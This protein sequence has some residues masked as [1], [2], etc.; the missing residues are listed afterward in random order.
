MADFDLAVIGSGP[1]GYVAAIRGAQNGL[2]VALIEEH[3]LGGICLNWGC[4]PTKALLRSAEVCREARQ[5]ASYGIKTESVTVD[6]PAIITRS[7]EVAKSNEAGVAFLMKK[8][9]IQ[10]VNGRAT[11]GPCN[12]HGVKLNVIS[13]DGSSQDLTATSLIIATGASPRQ[14]APYPAD[15]VHYLTYRQAMALQELPES[16]LVVGSG[17]IG[18]ELAWFFQTLGS[19][20]TV[21]ETL[22]Q[23]L[24][25]ED[26]E[27]SRFLA[28]SLTKQG[29]RC[30]PGAT[31]QQLQIVHDKVHASILDAKGN[32]V[33]LS[34]SKVLFAVGMIPNT[35]QLGLEAEGI[36]CDEKGFIVVDHLQRTT[37][38]NI[39]AIG[40]CTGKQ[41]LAHKASAEAEVAISAIL[42]HSHPD[43][44]YTQI[45]SALYCHPQVAS[46]GINEKRAQ[47]ANIEY[48]IGRYPFQASGKARAIGHSE[49][50]IKLLF[51][52]ES[53]QL[54]GAQIL[55]GDATEM[56]ATLGVAIHQKMTWE[57]IS[58]IVFAH[59]TL[60]EAFSEA[61]LASQKKAV[62]I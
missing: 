26:A 29:I 34:T 25:A 61:A 8:H 7:R 32:K 30:L 56:I 57:Q 1:G 47:A 49:G 24:P 20:V 41:M 60:S 53:G 2:R 62:H 9:K 5:A 6:F 3:Q 4:I 15:G 22:P 48:N 58:E 13:A 38:P 59:P 39:Y 11:I 35:S 51:H 16:L 18:L 46:I 52:K 10:V 50:F 12:E 27:V 37:L 31:L 45:P 23:I 44:D 43:L 42:G 40:D 33:E 14:L 54:L 17:A 28:L 36:A 55:G 21:V 19:S